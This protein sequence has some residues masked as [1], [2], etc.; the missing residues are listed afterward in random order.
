[1]SEH[2]DVRTDE[3]RAGPLADRHEALGA[4]MAPFAG[5]AMPIRYGSIAEEHR[6]VRTSV[7]VFDVSHLGTVRI[8]GRE[9]LEVVKASFTNDPTTLVD[10]RSQYT[11]CC[12]EQ[13]GVLDDLI[14]YRRRADRWLAVPNAANTAAV[15]A[16][17]Q[18]VAA[19]RDASVHDES[20]GWAVLA[21]Q[22]PQALALVDR[23][24]A[25]HGALVDVASATPHL[26]VREVAIAG[27]EAVLARTGYTG[28]RGVELML[29][30]DAAGRVWDE[31]R[32]AGARPVGLG[33][34]DTLRLEMGYP[35]HGHELSVD[36]SPYEVGLRW[37]VKLD[38]PAF[39]GQ[40]ALRD[41]SAGEPARRLI[42]LRAEG[43]RPLRE[44]MPVLV[45]DRVVGATT[46]GT[47]S[48]SLQV[49]I[50]LALVQRTTPP[51]AALQVDV[52]G[53][54]VPVERVRPPFLDRDPR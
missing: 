54:P 17:L 22:G 15:V 51:D 49:P 3:G 9:A 32:G 18:A 10:G 5:W 4:T 39:V 8:E 26:G 30:V 1:M 19:E 41:A 52:R 12:T 16:R 48:P 53:R 33:A 45:G 20:T 11:L 6:A 34:R 2:P 25:D 35:L 13:G 23:V 38:R 44:G 37:A 28:E 7:G 29:P 14:V 21:V 42:G 36:I 31:L 24:L 50:A 46:S 43:R 47:L 40:E 27:R